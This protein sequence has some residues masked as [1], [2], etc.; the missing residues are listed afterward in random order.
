MCL[1]SRGG[2]PSNIIYKVLK[3][4]K[5][6]QGSAKVIEFTRMNQISRNAPKSPPSP[7]CCERHFVTPVL[8]DG[9]D[10]GLQG[11]LQI[12]I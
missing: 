11:T 12:Y 6:A 4:I 9:R 8:K 2:K 7:G 3:K 5:M 10:D 1:Y